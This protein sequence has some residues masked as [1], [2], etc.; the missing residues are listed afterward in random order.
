MHYIKDNVLYTAK[1]SKTANAINMH[2][3]I[4]CLFNRALTIVPNNQLGPFCQKVFT[5]HVIG[6]RGMP[7]DWKL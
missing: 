7:C 3:A 6:T 4:L 1:C 2:T 5:W